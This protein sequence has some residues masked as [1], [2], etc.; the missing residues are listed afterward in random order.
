[1]IS[2]LTFW[3]QTQSIILLNLDKYGKT[4]QNKTPNLNIVRDNKSPNPGI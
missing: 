1:M 2:Q 4:K 3:G